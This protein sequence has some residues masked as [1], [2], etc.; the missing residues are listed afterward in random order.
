MNSGHAC[1]VIDVTTTSIA[2]NTPVVR[3]DDPHTVG[4]AI[5][6]IGLTKVDVQWPAVTMVRREALENVNVWTPPPPPVTRRRR[7]AA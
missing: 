7:R 1:N 6:M 3:V 5:R 2:P 4:L